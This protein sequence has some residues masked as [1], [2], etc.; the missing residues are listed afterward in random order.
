MG[1]SPSSVAKNLLQYQHSYA[2]LGPKFHVQAILKALTKEGQEALRQEGF[3]VELGQPHGRELVKDL[4]TIGREMATYRKVTQ[5]TLK[6]YSLAD[7][8]SRAVS[9]WHFKYQW[10][11]VF[12]RYSQNKLDWNGL[13][14]E[15]DM[16]AF[17]PIDQQMIRQKIVKGDQ[18]GAFNHAVRDV[19]DETQFPYRRGASAKATYGGLKIATQF[20]QW[21][22]EYAHM[23][24]RWAVTGQW[25]KLIRWHASNTLTYRTMADTFGIDTSSWSGV[26]P[27]KPTLSPALQ[28][29]QNLFG[30][31]DGF[32]K[33]NAELLEENAGELARRFLSNVIPVGVETRRLLNFKNSFEEGPKYD[34]GKYAIRSGTGKLIRYGTFTDLWL[35]AFG[36]YSVEK[37]KEEEEFKRIKNKE[38]HKAQATSRAMNLLMQGKEDEAGVLIEEYGLNINK[39]N[40]KSYIIPRNER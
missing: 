23:L 17:D 25:D 8:F 33:N 34:G 32:A 36:F 30:V 39:N 29:V 9:Y 27:L 20:G 5:A 28:T 31:I 2:R 35:S 40:W 6:P 12:A 15:L 26:D 3:L 22:I 24:K 11:D 19:I 38:F 4:D 13:E 10:D 14:R 37:T 16:G 7:A 1:L 21:P 18:E